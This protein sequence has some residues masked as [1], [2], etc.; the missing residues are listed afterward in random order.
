MILKKGAIIPI[1]IDDP[2]QLLSQYEGKVAGAHLLI[3][4]GNDAHAFMPAPIV[5]QDAVGRNQQVVVPFNSAV[6]LVVFSSQFHLSSTGMALG[7]GPT[8]IP[9]AVA[10]GQQPA[11]IV[12]QVTGRSAQ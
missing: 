11:A 5:S 8:T 10:T 9:V 1:R 4:V 12:L 7:K 6:N 2:S 3:G